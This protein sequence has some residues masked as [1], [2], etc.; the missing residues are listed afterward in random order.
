MTAPFFRLVS[1]GAHRLPHTFDRFTLI[2]YRS[3][4]GDGVWIPRARGVRLADPSVAAARHEVPSVL[5]LRPRGGVDDASRL[6]DRCA[7]LNAL[8]LELS[9]RC[10]NGRED[11]DRVRCCWMLLRD[12]LRIELE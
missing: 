7:S 5:W 6:E 4:A 1:G 3:D 2:L 12:A 8:A 10:V 9:F 11:A